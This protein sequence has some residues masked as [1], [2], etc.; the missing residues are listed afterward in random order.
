MLVIFTALFSPLNTTWAASDMQL[1]EKA[2][3]A[4]E[5]KSHN[6]MEHSAHAKPTDASRV[7]RGVFYGYLPCE[8]KDCDGIKVTLSLK[9][10][11]NYLL[12]TQYAKASTREYYE[13]GKYA[14]DEENR[15]VTLTP[16]KQAAKRQFSIQDEATL[17]QL[18]N[19]GTPIAGNQKDYTLQRSDAIKTRQVHI[20]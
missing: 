20:H 9:Q 1:M 4:R 17:I 19:D 5:G 14:W 12:V 2:L 6:A 3:K 16:K 8:Q 7:F 10:K 18:N 15:I 13:K 11:N